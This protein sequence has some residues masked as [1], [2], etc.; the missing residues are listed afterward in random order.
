MGWTSTKVEPCRKGCAR[1]TSISSKGHCCRG[2]GQGQRKGKC[3]G[4]QPQ[5][6]GGSPQAQL[7]TLKLSSVPSGT[8]LREE[9]RPQHSELR[10]REPHSKLRLRKANHTQSLGLGRIK[11]TQGEPGR[12]GQLRGSSSSAPRLQENN[13]SS[14]TEKRSS[15]S[16]GEARYN[17]NRDKEKEKML[18]CKNT[19]GER[20]AASQSHKS[21][22]PC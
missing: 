19:T 2:G 10:G 22:Y 11:L 9:S 4:L 1:G 21:T 15:G 13:E 16:G 3:R 17:N 20:T 5:R 18:K 14:S 7:K 8:P 12:M 6:P